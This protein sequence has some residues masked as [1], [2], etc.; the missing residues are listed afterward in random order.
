MRGFT[1]L[2]DLLMI[3]TVQNK[4]MF[5]RDYVTAMPI[6]R[7]ITAYRVMYWILILSV[8]LLTLSDLLHA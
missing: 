5:V 3:K 4:N 6:E 2:K 7:N 8:I 1:S